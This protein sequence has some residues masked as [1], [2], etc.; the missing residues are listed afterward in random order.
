MPLAN[1]RHQDSPELDKEI[2]EAISYQAWR[3]KYSK[4]YQ[5]EAEFSL[6][7][8]YSSIIFQL[9]ISYKLSSTWTKAFIPE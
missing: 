7:S 5:Q 8:I 9:L 1:L 2:A 4:R 6:I 3:A